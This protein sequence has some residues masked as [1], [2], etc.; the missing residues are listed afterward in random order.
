MDELPFVHKAIAKPNVDRIQTAHRMEPREIHFFLNL[1]NCRILI[2]LSLA[3][4]SFWKRP[5]PIRILHHGKVYQAVH[6][7]KHKSPGRDLG[8]VTLA[9]PLI[10]A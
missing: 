5:L 6:T 7:L 9:L 1:S 8:T 10:P 2:C 3:D 4:V